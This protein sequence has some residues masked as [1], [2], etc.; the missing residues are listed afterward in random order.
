MYDM[1]RVHGYHSSF[2]K[3]TETD[4]SDL[5][6]YKGTI[7]YKMVAPMLTRW[8]TVG[9]G[10][11][12]VFDYYL[13]LFHACQTVINIYPSGSTPNDIASD[14]FAMLKDQDNFIDMCLIRTFNKNCLNTHLDWLQ[15]S[16]D[17]TNACGFQSHHMAARCYLMETDLKNMLSGDRSKDYHLALGRG[18]PNKKE[19]HLKKLNVF[20]RA[21]IDSLYKHFDRWLKAPLLPAS[22]IA[23]APIANVV[24]AVIQ[25]ASPTHGIAVSPL[26][27]FANYQSS[28]H[29]RTICLHRFHRFLKKRTELIVDNGDCS[30]E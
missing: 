1:K 9:S 11:S 2:K 14:L 23:D 8:W 24:A 21:A 27:G 30:E 26:T 6:K 12:H 3:N 18:D 25:E 22:L 17:L 19:L 20:G 16:K 4:P 29:N 28:V 7:F 13:Q 15:S 5:T 10:A